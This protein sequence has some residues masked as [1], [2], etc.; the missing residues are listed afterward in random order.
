M[1]N[2]NDIDLSWHGSWLSFGREHKYMV[3]ARLGSIGLIE[4]ENFRVYQPAWRSIVDGKA[5]R[6]HTKALVLFMGNSGAETL[7]KMVL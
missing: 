1:D 3:I 2:A 5:Y 6:Y 4:N 7:A